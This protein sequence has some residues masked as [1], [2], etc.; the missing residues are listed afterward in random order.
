MTG[1]ARSR[2]RSVQAGPGRPQRPPAGVVDPE[3]V[4][5]RQALGVCRAG[6]EP[7]IK[8]STKPSIFDAGLAPDP[9]CKCTPFAPTDCMTTPT[10]RRLVVVMQSLGMVEQMQGGSGA[11]SL[12][13]GGVHLGLI[14][15]VGR[16][17]NNNR[18]C[19]TTWSDETIIG[20][21][22]GKGA[23]AWSGCGGGWRVGGGGRF[24][25]G[26][27]AG[28]GATRGLLG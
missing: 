3:R 13:S 6:L 21:L 23:S 27:G 14:E 11:I 18:N 25:P 12:W 8:P 16:S 7:S 9:P 15:G 5:C 10:Q 1:P 17:K 20:S 26:L 24:A 28:V 19:K 2:K 4:S 22:R